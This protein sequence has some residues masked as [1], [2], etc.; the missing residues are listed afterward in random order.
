METLIGGAAAILI[1]LVTGH[2]LALRTGRTS[3]E[4]TAQQNALVDL[5]DRVETLEKAFPTLVTR[6][7]LQHA[8]AQAAQAQHQAQQQAAAVA[9]QRAEAQ[10]ARQAAVFGNAGA[11]MPDS[12]EF[13]LMMGQQ[14]NALNSR[15]QQVA[16][17][18]GLG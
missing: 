8:F 7:E 2:T 14:L 6:Q 9:A 11:A 18:L 1:G 17:E 5:G 16:G 13:N 12:G 4:P 10:R 15:L 3:A